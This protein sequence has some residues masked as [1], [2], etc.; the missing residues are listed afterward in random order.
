[1]IGLGIGEIIGSLGLGKFLDK[2]GN[3]KTTFLCLILTA[4]SGL[5]SLLY[6]AIYQFNWLHAVLMCFAFGVQDG[7]VNTFNNTLLGF[8]F[9][10][11][12][13]PFS[14]GRAL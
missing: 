13:T 14:A 12:T 10:S 5:I 2:Y 7:A 6:I 9:E 4:V 3:R 8:Q 1:M 11:K